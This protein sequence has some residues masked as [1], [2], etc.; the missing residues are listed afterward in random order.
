MRELLIATTNA[1]KIREI[2]EILKDM[3]YRIVDLADVGY[4]R[5]IDEAGE[6][7]EE[8]ARLKAK[9]I[10]GE[11]EMLT[12]AEDSGLE[13]DVL[14]KKP[15]VYSARYCEGSDGDRNRKILFELQGIPREERTARFRSVVA[16]YEPDTNKTCVFGGATT[17]G[18]ITDE[19]MGENGFGYD[20][21]FYNPEL[22]KTQGEATFEEK[23]RVSHR[24]RALDGTRKYLLEIT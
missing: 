3:P 20:P 15:G 14:D 1:G 6:T 7:F 9:T 17:D 21:I 2:K 11:L 10:G 22:G 24:A 5:E 19:P 12:L 13:V 16:I 4:G 23:N 18:Y 8:N